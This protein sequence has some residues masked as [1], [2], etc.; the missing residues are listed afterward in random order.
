MYVLT[1]DTSTWLL[2]KRTA[3]ML[4]VTERN[5]AKA[6]QR[7]NWKAPTT[8]GY[9]KLALVRS[10]GETK[11]ANGHLLIGY[12]DIYSIQYFGENLRP[13]WNRT[14]SETIVSQ[15]QK[16]EQEYKTQMQNCAGFR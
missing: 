8:N 11:K 13:Y 5:F 15:F 6:L 2:K 14:G 16:A 12:D 3:L 7:T 9:D 10:L 1:G 4:S